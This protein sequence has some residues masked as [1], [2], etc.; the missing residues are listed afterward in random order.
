MG[1]AELQR[2]QLSWKWWV[3][4]KLC[5]KVVWAGEG[6]GSSLC[7]GSAGEAHRG[8]CCLTWGFSWWRGGGG[9]R[10]YW[11]K[12]LEW[13]TW[14]EIWGYTLAAASSSGSPAG[15]AKL[16][17]PATNQWLKKYRTTLRSLPSTLSWGLFC[18][19]TLGAKFCEQAGRYTCTV[20]EWT[21]I[22]GR[23]VH[24]CEKRWWFQHLD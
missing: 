14:R 21:D 8:R 13:R 11:I 18:A 7:S 10:Q 24:Y 22:M 9:L 12:L 16:F 6:L 23:G 19:N 17:T 1:E 3:W 20:S 15:F 2:D 5:A 4:E